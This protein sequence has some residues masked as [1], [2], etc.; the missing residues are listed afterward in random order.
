M[1]DSDQAKNKDV[2]AELTERKARLNRQLGRLAQQQQSIPHYEDTVSSL[3][4]L[5]CSSSENSS[6]VDE[7][8]GSN[9]GKG[10]RDELKD[11]KSKWKNFRGRRKKTNPTNNAIETPD[12]IASISASPPAI[13]ISHVPEMPGHIPIPT[14][15]TSSPTTTSIPSESQPEIRFIEAETN[16]NALSSSPSPDK[17]K[18]RGKS[19]MSPRLV[20]L[21]VYAVGVKCLGVGAHSGVV[22][23]PE[24]IFSLSET[25]INRLIKTRASS[26]TS[27]DSGTDIGGE[28]SVGGGEMGQGG[29][30][31]LIKH[32]QKNLVRIYPKG[33]RVNSSNY[34]PHRY[35]AAGAQVVAINWQTFGAW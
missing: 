20:S 13:T 1:S 21:L 12:Q 19:K 7:G 3:R 16:I 5:I 32:T 25:S 6:S 22:Y 15:N 26:R 29:L 8:E 23:S 17:I 34:E 30:K 9:G 18:S 27:M 2:I 31:E 11:L 24:H 10:L 4:A 28:S 33:S 35:W 14:L